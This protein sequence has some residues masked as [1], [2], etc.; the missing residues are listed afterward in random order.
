MILLD[1]DSFSLYQFGHARLLK[2]RIREIPPREA[3]I[4]AVTRAELLYGLARRPEAK[5]LHE[6][7][8]A[9]LARVQSLS[10]SN[11]A[12]THYAEIRAHLERNG[13]PIGNMDQMI[14]A[15][16]RSLDI[17]L[18]TG[19]AAHFGRIPGVALLDWAR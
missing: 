17:P 18:V 10:W 7:V 5:R 2:S 12:A 6:V 14:A 16:A 19:N 13:E 15:H 11:E 3:C 8:R 1:T 9:F 4:S